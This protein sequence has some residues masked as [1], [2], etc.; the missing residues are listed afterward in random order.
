[1]LLPHENKESYIPAAATAY[2]YLQKGHTF[3]WSLKYGADDHHVLIGLQSGSVKVEVW[4]Q[5]AGKLLESK[6]VEF[7]SDNENKSTLTLGPYTTIKYAYLNL[8]FTITALEGAE[9]KI[10]SRYI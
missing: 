8:R 10:S 1:M 3:D 9:Y 7:V 4:D 5:K 2:D 6:Q